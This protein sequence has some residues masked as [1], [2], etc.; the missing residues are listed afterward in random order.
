MRTRTA[1]VLHRQPMDV[2]ADDPRRCAC[3][4]AGKFHEFNGDKWGDDVPRCERCNVPATTVLR[5]LSRAHDR[6]LAEGR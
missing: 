6:L 3:A 1:T 5:D 4:G 2:P